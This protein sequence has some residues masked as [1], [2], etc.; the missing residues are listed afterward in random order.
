MP[1]QIQAFIRVSDHG[2]NGSVKHFSTP[3]INDPDLDCGVI[4]LGKYQTPG[5]CEVIHDEKH[6]ARLAT[7]KSGE[8]AFPECDGCAAMQAVLGFST[9]KIINNLTC[10]RFAP[11]LRRSPLDM[12][13]D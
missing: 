13:E 11:H 4:D 5:N 7:I 12:I 6:D 8:L 10:W 9:G 1:N 2:E 3:F